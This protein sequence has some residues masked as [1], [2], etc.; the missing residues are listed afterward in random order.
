[1]VHGTKNPYFLSCCIRNQQIEH[2][3]KNICDNFLGTLLDI[4]GKSKDHINSSYDLYEMG[5]RKEIQPL[6]DF[7]RGNIHLAKACFSMK[8]YKKKLYCTVLK[9][10]KLPKGCSSN[11][12]S[13]V[14]N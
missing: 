12:S 13:R 14:P 4:L 10:A 8:S 1:M 5:I 11:I 2:I 7:D 6:K 9:D 3:E